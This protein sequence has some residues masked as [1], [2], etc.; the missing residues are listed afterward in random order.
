MVSSR[1]STNLL[2]NDSSKQ[3]GLNTAGPHYRMLPRIARRQLVIL[4]YRQ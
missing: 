4:N 3:K 1:P 2:K